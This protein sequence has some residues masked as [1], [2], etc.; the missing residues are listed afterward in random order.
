MVFA[1]FFLVLANGNIIKSGEKDKLVEDEPEINQE[2]TEKKKGQ[3]A[4]RFSG[5]AVIPLADLTLDVLQSVL[6]AIGN[7]NRKIAIGIGNDT[8]YEFNAVGVYFHSGTSDDV[9]PKTVQTAE[10]ATYPARRTN[11]PTGTGVV[12]VLCYYMPVPDKSLCVLFSVPFDYNLYSNWW[13]ANIYPGVVMPDK[14]LYNVMKF[15]VPYPGD[16][17]NHYRKL[18]DFG[19]IMEDGIMSSS[20]EAKLMLTIGLNSK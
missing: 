3:V 2:I 13:A 20:G 5:S 8:P 16:D 9:L 7:I 18:L 10:A 6:N 12:G 4:K 19:F 15:E 11:G 1:V 17:I 14:M